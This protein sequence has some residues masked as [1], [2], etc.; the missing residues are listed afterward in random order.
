MTKRINYEDNIF[1]L[2]L[3]LKQITSAFKL[4]IDTELFR[5]KVVEDLFF[6][7]RTI[8][9]IFSSLKMNSLII[10]RLDHLKDLQ[11]LNKDFV[12]LLED[13]LNIHSPFAHYLSDL[14]EDL[15]NIKENHQQDIV[16]IKEIITGS[17]FSSVEEDQ[18]VSA[19]E[20]KILLSQEE[21]ED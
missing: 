14:F 18:M 5:D 7:D 10:D 2:K 9:G 20:F 16:E 19:E 11:K 8:N 1:F 3:I 6:L 21:G 15:Q 12:Q 4:S 13:T 17:R